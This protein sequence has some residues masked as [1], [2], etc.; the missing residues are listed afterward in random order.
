MTSVSIAAVCRLWRE[1]DR[2]NNL[3][4]KKNRGNEAVSYQAIIGAVY[5]VELAA[6]AHSSS[7]S[8]CSGYLD[9]TSGAVPLV[10]VQTA[11]KF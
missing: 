11:C 7:S 8:P 5:V 3:E 9:R 4:I 6:E 10:V 2:T 1:N